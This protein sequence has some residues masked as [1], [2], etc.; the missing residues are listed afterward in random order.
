MRILTA[1]FKFFGGKI[2]RIWTDITYRTNNEKI[3]LLSWRENCNFFL[4]TLNIILNCPTKSQNIICLSFCPWFWQMSLTRSIL[5]KPHLFFGIDL[6]L[7]GIIVFLAASQIFKS[8]SAK[9]EN[10]NKSTNTK[11]IVN[12]ALASSHDQW[13]IKWGICRRRRRCCFFGCNKPWLNSS[14]C[15]HELHYLHPNRN[16]FY[17]SVVPELKIPLGERL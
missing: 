5:A 16:F 1:Y 11:W 8:Q 13:W 17:S 3:V 6:S 2:R 15:V 12:L 4:T 10:S 9:N 7:N 14:T